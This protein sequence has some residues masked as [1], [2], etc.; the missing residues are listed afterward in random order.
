MTRAVTGGPIIE[1]RNTMRSQL[2]KGEH[3]RSWTLREGG[4]L[5]AATFRARIPFNVSRL[6]DR[7]SLFPREIIEHTL[8][9]KLKDG[10]QA[11]DGP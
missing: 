5:S 6:G 1:D 8:A 10:A 2:E 4:E 9:H 7:G 3:L 11:I